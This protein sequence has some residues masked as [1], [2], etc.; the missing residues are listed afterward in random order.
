MGLA[1]PGGTYDTDDGLLHSPPQAASDHSPLYTTVSAPSS[2]GVS[3]STDSMQDMLGGRFHYVT[4]RARKVARGVSM[5]DLASGGEF[6][7]PPETPRMRGRYWSA[8][9]GGEDCEDT[10]YTSVGRELEDHS[11]FLASSST[12][13]YR[14]IKRNHPDSPLPADTAPADDWRGW[15]TGTSKPRDLRK[16]SAQPN[17]RCPEGVVG[18]CSADDPSTIRKAFR[19]E[20]LASHPDKGAA[21]HARFVQVS[22]AHR[23][24]ITSQRHG[25]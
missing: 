24:W 13:S 18:C 7:S 8:I 14:N 11:S 5:A 22:T 9:N 20:L 21:D 3:A 6:D 2:V 23:Q 16:D 1:C 10:V 12:A 4:S 17:L 15:N 19:R 25:A